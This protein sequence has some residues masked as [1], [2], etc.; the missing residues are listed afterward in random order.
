MKTGVNGARILLSIAFAQLTEDFLQT[1]VKACHGNIDWF[2]F[3]GLRCVFLWP[4]LAR[5][6]G[7]GDA[8]SLIDQPHEPKVVGAFRHRFVVVR[9][10]GQPQ[11][12]A[13][14]DDA[15]FG[16]VRLDPVA[17]VTCRTGQLFF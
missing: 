16:M 11:Q 6:G 1:M 7:G 15:Q 17:P 2:L 12:F 4:D 9:A 8:R 13:L 5:P 14:G 10:A 3:A